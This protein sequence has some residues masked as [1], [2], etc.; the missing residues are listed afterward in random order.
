MK[1]QKKL[2]TK[3]M[4]FRGVDFLSIDEDFL[5]LGRPQVVLLC[6]ILHTSCHCQCWNGIDSGPDFS[7]DGTAQADAR[8]LGLNNNGKIRTALG[9]GLVRGE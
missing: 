7:E 2:S 1:T 3:K 4:L 5:W 9:T 6:A 8:E